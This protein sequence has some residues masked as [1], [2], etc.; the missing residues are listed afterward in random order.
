VYPVQIPVTA[1]SLQLLRKRNASTITK[2]EKSKTGI[3][4]LNLGGPERLE[5]VHNFLLRLFSDQ[6][7]IQLPAQRFLAPRIAKRR[8]P[9]IQEKYSEIGGG[10]PI[11]MWTEKQGQLMVKILDHISPESAPHK[12]YIGFRYSRPLTEETIDQMEK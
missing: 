6:D 3:L 8:T 12:H 4:L 2:T 11:R 10:S 1:L 5:D 9:K 7:L